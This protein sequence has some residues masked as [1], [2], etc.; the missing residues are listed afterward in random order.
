MSSIALIIFGLIIGVIAEIFMFGHDLVGFIIITLV[1]IAA[2]FMGRYIG[3][4]LGLFRRPRKRQGGRR[5]MFRRR[6]AKRDSLV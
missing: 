1:G 3:R 4:A 6:M 5:S 2:I